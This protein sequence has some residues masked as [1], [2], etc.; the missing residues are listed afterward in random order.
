MRRDDVVVYLT[1]SAI[2]HFR[3]MLLRGDGPLNCV[4]ELKNAVVVV[5]ATYDLNADGEAVW[6]E[7]KWH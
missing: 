4:C 7:A 2:L 5:S 1:A 3:S 6:S